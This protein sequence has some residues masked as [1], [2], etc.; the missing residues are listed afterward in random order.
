[1]FFESQVDGRC[2]TNLQNQGAHP[3]GTYCSLH[4]PLDDESSLVLGVEKEVW[5]D[6]GMEVLLDVIRW[7]SDR[8]VGGVM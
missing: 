1:M 4:G 7:Y 3:D 6:T 2:R 5:T 8:D